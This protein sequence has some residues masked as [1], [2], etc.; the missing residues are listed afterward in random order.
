[1]R[2]EECME[3]A[4]A[5]PGIL[6]EAAPQIGDV[7]RQEMALEDAEDAAEVLHNAADGLLEG[8]ECNEDGDDVAEYIDSVCDDDCVVTKDFSPLE[9]GVAEHKYYA[10]GIGLIMEIDVENI[11]DEEDVG[12]CLLPEGVVDDDDDDDEDD[13]E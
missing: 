7:Y 6:M 3:S 9:P 2:T 8:D 10:P 5:Q 12:S 1:M 11:E 4:C 13:E